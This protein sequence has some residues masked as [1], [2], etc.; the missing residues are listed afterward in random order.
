MQT[1]P[2]II[3]LSGKKGSGKNTISRFI[4]EYF[5]DLW[6]KGSRG[7]LDVCVEYAF[8]DLLKG[9]CIKVLGLKHS[10]CYGSDADKETPTQ[11][12]WKNIPS[13][14]LQNTNMTGREVMQVFGTECVRSW[15]GNVWADATL[16]QIKNDNP[17]LAI[18]TDN[19]F[20]SEVESILKYQRG[21]I[22]RLTR[23][24]FKDDHVS[25]TSLDDFDWNHEKCYLLDNTSLSK[26]EQNK[27]IRP[28]LDK[29]FCQEF[30]DAR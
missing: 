6:Y 8:A 14:N 12:P 2:V 18:V 20:L 19:R 23:A 21:Y 28:I 24:P 7:G 26:D 5:S 30:G 29:I 10:Q 1:A 17:L 3:A 9:F 22:V 4:R 16:R 13:Q 25:E 15:F 27:A 11:Y